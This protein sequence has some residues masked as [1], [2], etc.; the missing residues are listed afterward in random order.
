MSEKV[1]L[2]RQLNELAIAFG[3]KFQSAQTGF[4]HYCYHIQEGESHLAIPTV[5]N[6]L[7]ALALLKSRSVDNANEAKNLLEALLHF[8]NKN[9]EEISNGNFPIYLHEFPICKDRFTGV[10]AGSAI[11]WIL[12]L[13]HNILGQNLKKRLE[14]SFLNIL[15]HALKMQN[16]K[17]APYALSVQIASLAK[18]GGIMLQ[19][20]PI[21]ACGEE[22]LESLRT[23]TES[24]YWH[25]PMAMGTM[26]TALTMVY[27]RLSDSP[28][29][30][31]W[32]YL[33]Q[34]W[35][36][37][38]CYYVG[39][40]IREWQQGY[41][42]QVSIYDLFL[43][44]FSGRFSD[45][46][47]RESLVHLEAALI[48]SYED[49]LQ[50][51]TYPLK[52]D[53]SLGKAKGYV[54]HGSQLAFSFVEKKLSSNLED[55][56]F[57]P[58]KIV[59]GNSSRIHTFVVQGGNSKEIEFKLVPGG[60][61]LFFDLDEIQEIEDRE[62]TREVIFFIDAHDEL[63]QRISGQKATTF[64]LDEQ[65]LLRSGVFNVS[66]KF[67]LE[68]G[69][70]KFLGHRMLGNRPSQISLKGSRRYDAYDWQIFLRTLKRS[71][72]C[73]IKASLRFVE[74]G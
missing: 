33:E 48:Q 61:D 4:I 29:K 15:R 55:R 18:A 67:S 3:R 5:E 28:W 38:T 50:E 46:A 59:W 52:L 62:K 1:E 66:L 56:A 20:Q 13:F 35:H 69:E 30:D 40:A 9:A 49:T 63:E 27:P 51:P 41:E 54:E 22:L 32:K 68:R 37:Q 64:L 53:Q 16:E 6:F 7:F 26:L 17:P 70:G 23:T 39:P 36:R 21:E 73:V 14:E 25:S 72:S 42:P 11:Y 60:I 12:K 43:G 10:R 74:E 44:Y 71:E 8:Q 34:T 47:L 65:I 19:N 24:L 2:L 57:Y 45:R 31:F 58:L